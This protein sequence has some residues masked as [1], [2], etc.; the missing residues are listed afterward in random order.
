LSAG[1][2]FVPDSAIAFVTFR[3]ADWPAAPG[4]VQRLLQIVAAEGMSLGRKRASR[5]F[6]AL[7]GDAYV[8]LLKLLPEL[9]STSRYAETYE[10]FTFVVVPP[11]SIDEAAAAGKSGFATAE[12]GLVVLHSAKEPRNWTEA[13]SNDR[14]GDAPQSRITA[15][16]TFYVD[17]VG[18][19]A[20][21]QLD[22]RTY[23]LTQVDVMQAYLAGIAASQHQGRIHLLLEAAARHEGLAAAVVANVGSADVLP[24]TM[25][26]LPSTLVPFW[27]FQSASLLA[28]P[29]GDIETEIDEVRFE[30]RLEYV[31]ALA[32]RQAAAS[33]AHNVRSAQ[34]SFDIARD[35]LMSLSDYFPGTDDF[36]K[37]LLTALDASDDALANVVVQ[38]NGGLVTVHAQLG[39]GAPSRAVAEGAAELSDAT[40]RRARR[41]SARNLHSIG[42]ALHEYEG[43]NRALPRRVT[44]M[45]EGGPQT[46]WRV[47][48]LPFLDENELYQEYRQDEPWDSEHNRALL[49]RIPRVYQ[50]PWQGH[51][52]DFTTCY[53][54]AGGS[55]NAFPDAP[56]P[57]LDAE[58]MRAV[59]GPS[60]QHGLPIF[61]F[62]DGLSNVL[63]VVE[64][65]HSVPWTMPD[66]ATVNSDE[67]LPK[68]GGVFEDGFHGLFGDGTV[69]FV[70]DAIDEPTLRALFTRRGGELV[71]VDKL[72]DERILRATRC[73]SAWFE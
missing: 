53:L 38:D 52:S 61:S 70:P 67:P 63:L 66:D 71:F 21:V 50:I 69:W 54:A 72:H 60:P 55:G 39:L 32:A 5:G 15:G 16:R 33:F 51:E 1:L 22:D 10:R 62:T 30:L 56:E 59:E 68:L 48:I 20:A 24:P 9:L 44:S 17:S 11:V 2:Q 58:I 13:L 7:T 18:A 27:A 28:S 8:L 3:T 45:T 19:V 49:P 42:L 40:S 35:D 4:E 34:E 14:F 25:A 43:A 31:D 23:A 46:S 12:S 73:D 37:A 57:P 47:R 41:R 65:S 64:S 6:R 36:R 26:T 29:I